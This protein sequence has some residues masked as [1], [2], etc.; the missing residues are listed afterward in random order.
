M[1]RVL[2][3]KPSSYYDWLSRDISD[4]QIHRNQ[5]ELLVRAAHSETRECYGADRL[6]AKLIEQ[7]HDIS[8]Y[9]VRRIKEEH[10][11]K[12]RRHK[13]FKVTTDS[14]H[15]KMVYPN[16][17]DQQFDAKRPNESWVSDIT[18]IWTNEG[19]LYLAGVKDLYTKELVGYA[20]N[21]RMTA[22]LV[23]RA[24]NMA[25]KN[26]RPSKELIVHS[27]RGSQYCSHAYHKIIKQHQFTG[28]MSGRGNCFDNAPI[29]SFLGEKHCFARKNEL[30]YHQDYK[31]RF[32]AISDI[33]GYIELY[34]NQTRIQKGLAYKSPRQVWFDYY[35]QAA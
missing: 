27:D 16:V 23:C 21:N 5:S 33:I 9:M 30:V 10:G 28:S 32:T 22:D 29:E 31:T 12:C 6:H 19:W 1:C 34:Y 25:I 11:I 13:R 24:L 18:Y 7:G 3:V 35:R 26:K 14:N 4:Q 20:I 2:S 15:N 17:L 8:L